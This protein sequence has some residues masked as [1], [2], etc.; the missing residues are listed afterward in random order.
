[1]TPEPSWCTVYIDKYIH[2]YFIKFYY[3]MAVDL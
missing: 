3:F 1:M 2:K